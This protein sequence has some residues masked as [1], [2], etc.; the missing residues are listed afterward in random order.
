MFTERFNRSQE[1][2]IRIIELQG[3]DLLQYTR[4][5]VS[6]LLD[7]EHDRSIGGA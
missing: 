7:V 2:K 4:G 5:N 3:S 6:T 1:A